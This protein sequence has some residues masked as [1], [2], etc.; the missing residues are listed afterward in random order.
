[1]VIVWIATKLPARPYALDDG[2][3]IAGDGFGAGKVKIDC[4]LGHAGGG[5]GVSG[6]KRT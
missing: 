2:A 4:P 3:D 1:M 5:G 6:E